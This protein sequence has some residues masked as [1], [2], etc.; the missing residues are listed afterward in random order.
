VTIARSTW[1]RGK[2]IAPRA[3]E[4]TRRAFRGGAASLWHHPELV[5]VAER[6]ERLEGAAAFVQLCGNAS[7]ALRAGPGA[8]I[9]EV[10]EGGAAPL[11]GGLEG[12]LRGRAGLC[13]AEADE[14]RVHGPHGGAPGGAGIFAEPAEGIGEVAVAA[15]QDGVVAVEGDRG[16]LVC[17]AR[18]QRRARRRRAEHDARPVSEGAAQGRASIRRG[19]AVHVG[20][21]D[22]AREVHALGAQV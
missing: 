4:A 18:H 1:T 14:V 10:V 11:L 15:E 21:Q 12:I 17:A 19:V 2:G 7:G 13:V 22:A 5:G 20:A 8:E 3:L 6:W 16:A 9:A